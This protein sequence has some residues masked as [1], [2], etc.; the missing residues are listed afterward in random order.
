MKSA[1]FISSA[2]ASSG[3]YA[4]RLI[5]SLKNNGRDIGFFGVGTPEMEKLGF[6]RIGK[7][8]EMAVVGIFEVIPKIAL[9]K[10]VLEKTTEEIKKR[11]PKL[12]I[13]MDYSGFNLRLAKRIKHLGIPMIY[14]VSPQIWAWK[15]YRINLIKKYIDKMIV[16]LPFEESF[17]KENGIEAE[18]VGHPL[19]DEVSER[20]LTREY[21]LAE[22][23]KFGVSEKDHLLGLMPGSRRSEIRNH[24][25][26]Q[27][28][29]AEIVSQKVPNLKIAVLVAPTLSIEELQKFMP[30]N[31]S[32]NLI[33]VKREPFEMV[34]ICDTILCASGTAT[35]TVGILEK[36][37][38]I[39]YKA[40]ALSAFLAKQIIKLPNF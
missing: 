12:I 38:V 11:K 24:L 32:L 20:I 8:E 4:Q 30:E 6:E 16:I 14:Y 13:L 18:F 26:T 3:L 35:L 29:T 1:V 21:Q 10:R 17:Y 25:E 9:L 39:M 31:H 23:S 19:L 33:F 28:K 5:E 34:S 2:E 36:P 27:L 37:M 40:A 15:K 22:R 7:S